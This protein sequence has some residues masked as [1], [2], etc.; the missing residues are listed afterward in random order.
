[1][2]TLFMRSVLAHLYI[3]MSW[4][5]RSLRQQNK[6]EN[7]SPLFEADEA[8]RTHKGHPSCPT[9]PLTFIW[10]VS[11]VSVHTLMGSSTLGYCQISCWLCYNNVNWMH[12]GNL[13]LGFWYILF[14]LPAQAAKKKNSK[15]KWWAESWK[16]S[17][18]S[19]GENDTIFS[20]ISWYWKKEM[21]PLFSVQ[22]ISF[23]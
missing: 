4:S 14:L 20:A 13:A 21:V 7:I 11:M 19:L 18:Y 5:T 16:T 1:M 6:C 8:M 22:R 2:N 3:S 23:I 10:Q 12:N 9:S 15:Y 17:T